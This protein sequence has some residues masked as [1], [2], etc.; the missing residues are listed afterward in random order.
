[1]LTSS[2]GRAGCIS[3]TNRQTV[4]GDVQLECREGELHQGD[5]LKGGGGEALKPDG[6]ED[7]KCRLAVVGKHR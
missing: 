4:R 5:W 7:G 1:M 3:C 2:V 6:K